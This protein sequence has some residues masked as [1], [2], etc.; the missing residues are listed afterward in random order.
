MSSSIISG[1][2]VSDRTM[3]DHICGNERNNEERITE[4]ME[5]DNDIGMN[6]KLIP[7]GELNMGSMGWKDSLPCHRV[8]ITRPFYIGTY[9]V[10]QWEWEAVM[11]KFLETERER[12]AALKS[13]DGLFAVRAGGRQA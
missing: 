6:F 8:S 12:Q 9:P 4:K 10:T 2:E 7:A 5:F 13:C 3:F 11:G 1:V